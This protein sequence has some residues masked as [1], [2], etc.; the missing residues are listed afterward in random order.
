MGLAF[1]IGF[2]VGP[3][4]GA[5]FALNS[6]LSSGAWGERPAMYALCLSL[7][8]ILLVLFFIPETLTK[9]SISF[10]SHFSFFLRI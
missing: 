2:I 4:T 3:V 9:V 1:S 5:W 10:A 6:D 7:A 8:N